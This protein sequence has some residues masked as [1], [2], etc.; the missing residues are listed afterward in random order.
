MNWIALESNTK[1]LKAILILIFTW[2]SVCFA[3][4]QDVIVVRDGE[5]VI[6]CSVVELNDSVI[7]YKVKGAAYDTLYTI[8]RTEVQ[9]YTLSKK[10]KVVDITSGNSREGILGK[11][12]IGEVRP[13]YIVMLSGD[14]LFGLVK[15]KDIAFN[16]LQID[17]I[18]EKGDSRIY[19]PNEAVAYGYDLIHYRSMDPGYKKE[20]TCEKRSEG[21]MFLEIIEEGPAKIFQLVTL[22]YPKSVVNA[23]GDPP[24]WYGTLKIGYYIVPPVGEAR[25]VIGSSPRNNLIK[26]FE[27]D[28]DLVQGLIDDKPQLK[29]VPAIVSKY[30]YWYTNIKK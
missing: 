19:S 23:Y 8:A 1:F 28:T 26:L 22:T 16:Q 15:I 21:A 3:H 27:D 9:S 10:A 6:D 14:T 20:I 18:D 2:A 7:V 29:D 17:W 25:V 5:R 30:N 24:I 11:Y 4:G 12:H 13:G